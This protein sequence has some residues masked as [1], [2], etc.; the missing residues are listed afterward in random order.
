MASQ[1]LTAGSNPEGTAAR[2]DFDEV[3]LSLGIHERPSDQRGKCG[4]QPE[5][6]DG[7]LPED[8]PPDRR[9]E[10]PGHSNSNDNLRNESDPLG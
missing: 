7:E 1:S 10:H 8:R 5:D 3:A 6:A 2:A 4:T 9:D